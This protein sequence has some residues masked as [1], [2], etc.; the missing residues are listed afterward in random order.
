MMKHN[1]KKKINFNVLSP[2]AIP[3]IVLPR[4]IVGNNTSINI[5]TKSSTIS[6]PKTKS[7]NRCFLMF[8]SLNALMIMVVEDMDIIDPKKKLS[9]V[10]QP[11]SKP[12]L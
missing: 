11:S 1:I 6:T 3:F 2:R 5:P 10:D 9:M 4:A 12:T 8:K 7:V